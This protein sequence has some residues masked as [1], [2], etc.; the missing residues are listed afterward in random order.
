[1]YEQSLVKTVE[2]IKKTTISQWAYINTGTVYLTDYD[3][4]ATLHLMY[5][6]YITATAKCIL[7]DEM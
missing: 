1:M 3:E 2:P 5:K 6:K 4:V 7:I